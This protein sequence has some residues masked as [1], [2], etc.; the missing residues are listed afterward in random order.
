ME[1]WRSGT[2]Y[3]II[4]A[5]S[6]KSADA[7]FIIGH[8]FNTA[9]ATVSLEHSATGAWAGEEAE[10]VAGFTPS[11]DKAF[12]K[13]FSSVSARYWRVKMV[14]AATA[15]ECAVVLLGTVFTYEKYPRGNFDPQPEKRYTKTRISGTGN[16]LGVTNKYYEM[17]IT[18]SFRSLTPSWVTNTFKSEWESLR[19]EEHTSELQSH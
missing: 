15:A 2:K 3:L 8:N 11:N 5:G 1:G 14:T 13:T 16:V 7:L 4:D 12:L 10:D 9:S 6:A 18:A 19:S 17:L